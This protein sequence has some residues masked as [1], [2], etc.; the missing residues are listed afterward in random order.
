MAVFGPTPGHSDNNF[1]ARSQLRLPLIVFA[2]GN[3]EGIINQCCS[4]CDE[5][6]LGCVQFHLIGFRCADGSRHVRE[7]P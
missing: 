7:P 3:P 4:F 5:S 2:F 6:F 1:S